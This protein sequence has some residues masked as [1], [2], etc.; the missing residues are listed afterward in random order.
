MGWRN[1]K[2]W[3]D[4]TKGSQ[5]LMKGWGG[6]GKRIQKGDLC[7]E[8]EGDGMID[9]TSS[10]EGSLDHGGSVAIAHEQT[11]QVLGLSH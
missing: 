10:V 5:D 6:G 4:A 9:F 2:I 8:G 11:S 3:L 7:G 1:S